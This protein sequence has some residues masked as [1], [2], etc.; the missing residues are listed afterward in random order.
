MDPEPSHLLFAVRDFDSSVVYSCMVISVLLIISGLIAAGETAFFSFTPT[1]MKQIADANT[2]TSK[3]IIQITENPKK[4][5]AT[6]LLGNNLIMIAIIILFAE[7]IDQLFVFDEGQEYI[8]FLLDAIGVTFLLLIVCEVVPKVYA[9]QNP[10]RVANFMALPIQFLEISLRPLTWV[11]LSTTSIIDKRIKRK[12]ADITVDELGHALELTFE[13]QQSTDEKKILEGIVK[14]GNTSVSQIMR[15]RMDVIAIDCDTRFDELVPLIIS[16]GYSRLPVYKDTLDKIEG[17]LVTKD[18]LPYLEEKEFDWKKLLRDPFFVPENKKI[19]DLLADFKHERTHMAIVVDEYGGTTGVVTLEDVLEEIV[20]EITDEFDDEEITYTKIDDFNYVFEGK[21]LLN[22]IYKILK[23]DGDVF[24]KSKGESDTLAGFLLEI[25]GRFL[26]RNEKVKFDKYLFTVE[27]IDKKRIKQ[28]KI[29]INDIYDQL[30]NSLKVKTTLVL[31]P[32]FF[33]F[34]SCSDSDS[35]TPRPRGYFRIELPEKK[36]D[37]VS[38]AEQPFSFISNSAASFKQKSNL[39][40][41]K[42]FSV[43]DYPKLRATFYFTHK[44]INDTNLAR[45]IDDCHALAYNHTGKADDII[46]VKIHHPSNSVYGLIYEFKGNAA[47]PIQFYV[48]DS[49]KHFLR[50]SLYFY[51]RP[52]Y[53]SILP[54]LNYVRKDL[55]TILSTLHWKN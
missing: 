43:L 12:A 23:I 2:S 11:L 1:D 13:G 6:V 36:F 51:A 25:S 31:L 20:G 28:V 10:L 14:F 32:F 21:T 33:L 7:L 39:D 4:L 53:D 38:V 49:T 9:N 44:T 40:A 18:L 50:G 52:N 15:S 54:V 16:C 55:D 45:M 29:T 24:E 30:E 17:I 41:E 34:T 37:T 42:D 22:D 26:N 47:T 27:A 5:L 35:S 3:R 19:D 46:P 48:T 8:K